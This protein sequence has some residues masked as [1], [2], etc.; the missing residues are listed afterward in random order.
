MEHDIVPELLKKI[1]KD[2]YDHAEKSGELEKLLLLLKDGKAT[3]KESYRFATKIGEILSTALQENINNDVLPEG[4]M[5]FNIANRILNEMLETNHKMVSSYAKNIQEEL[6]KQAGLGL[7]SVIAPI[8]QDRIDGLVNR[9]SHESSFDDV[10]WILGAPVVNFSQNV[11]DNHIKANAEFHYKSGLKA[12]VIRTT[13]GK[14]CDWCDKLAGVYFYPKVDKDVFRR[15]D[16]CDCTVEYY[17]GDGKKQDVWSKQWSNEKT[18]QQNKN[19]T[20]TIHNYESVKEEWLKNYKEAKINDL[21]YWK[22]D[23]QTLPVDGRHVILDYSK[24]E[25]EIGKWMANTFGVH[26][27]MVP[28][29]NY[30]DKVNTPDYL[31]N[32]KRFDLKEITGNSKNTIDQNCRKAKKQAENII[33][34]ITNSLLSDEEVLNQLDSIYKRGIRGINISVI[35]RGNIVIDVLKKKS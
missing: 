18:K 15:H 6:N 22:V 14:C 21:L 20:N 28:R 11:V 27:Q 7:K 30:P 12:K 10:S 3:Y 8:N 1:K 24:K 29:V 26:V 9:L 19:T 13:N 17:P 4:K 33:F 16:R 34:D 23:G 35:K 31:I 25:K 32:D 2:F 5:H